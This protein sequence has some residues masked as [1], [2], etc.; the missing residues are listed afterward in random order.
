MWTTIESERHSSL[1]RSAKALSIF[2]DAD[3]HTTWRRFNTNIAHGGM[4]RIS[5]ASSPKLGSLLRSGFVCG[6]EKACADD[7]STCSRRC[8]FSRLVVVSNK[9]KDGTKFRFLF[10]KTTNLQIRSWRFQF[11]II[12]L[13]TEHSFRFVEK[14]QTIV[15]QFTRFKKHRK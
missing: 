5:K 10:E 2:N 14:T 9:S 4:A 12:Y 3:E 6:K 13:N 1:G 7:W 11:W 15:E 8:F